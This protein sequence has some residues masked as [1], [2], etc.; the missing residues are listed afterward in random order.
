MEPFPDLTVVEPLLPDET[1]GRRWP[2]R[3]HW[4]LAQAGWR[5]ID[6]AAIPQLQR[7][8][9][10]EEG[11]TVALHDAELHLD[12]AAN[13]ALPPRVRAQHFLLA[14]LAIGAAIDWLGATE[15]LQAMLDAWRAAGGF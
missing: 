10:Y 7:L 11:S 6:G 12:D 5:A 2:V 14:G 15:A 9:R 3:H 13:E 8:L 4:T 1:I